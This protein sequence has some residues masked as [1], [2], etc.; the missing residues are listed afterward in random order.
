MSPRH[1]VRGWIAAGLAV[2]A[3]VGIGFGGRYLPVDTATGTAEGAT[4]APTGRTSSVCTTSTAT[5]PSFSAGSGTTG[6]Q[7]YAVAAR[8]R[9]GAAGSLTGRDLGAA[10]SGRPTLS[11]TSQGDGDTLQ[12]PDHA[13]VLTADGAMA[14]GSAAM[15]YGRSQHGQDRGLSL[16]PCTAPAV[17][18]WFTGLGASATRSS[19]LVLSNPDDRQAQ[20]DLSF[21]GPDGL[22][23]V[24]GATGLTVPAGSG[25]TLSLEQLLGGLD[26]E[27]AV[28]VKAT[29]GR[30]AAIARDL[31]AARNHTPTGA[32]WHPVSVPPATRQIL[33]AIPGGDGTRDLVVTNPGKRRAD[34][35]IEVL[36]PDGPFAPA[37]AAETSV[38]AGSA[39]TIDV[40]QGLAGRIGTLR[41][42]STQPVVTAVRSETTGAKNPTDIAVE[43]S[44]P[45]ISPLGIAPVGVVGGAHTEFALSNDGVHIATAVVT[46][47]DLDGV[48]LY[49]EQIPVPPGGS[50]ERRVN[51]AGPAYLTV[52]STAG[53]RLYG[54]LTLRQS[55]GD[56]SGLAS[57]GFVTPGVA[58]RP[59]VSS[60]DPHVG[61]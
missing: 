38:D 43:T 59:R 60:H 22:M 3:A 45:V 52:R 42:T 1:A 26:G 5:D 19:Q 18:Q 23:S 30:V 54:G 16:A 20:V 21:Y 57:A 2:V 47:T 36:G 37:G 34:V 46:L 4:S 17:D 55:S 48:R 8:V 10:E 33:P 25:R 51:Q 24:P 6:S 39:T 53:A 35:R 40:A 49:Q 11:I 56:V 13:V 14:A 58:G 15:V 27:I 32:D 29:T 41:V 44:Q 7:V 61:Q 9:A 28:E 12:N 31:R 50:V